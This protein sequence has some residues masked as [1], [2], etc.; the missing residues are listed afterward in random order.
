MT[1]GASRSVTLK[2]MI[3]LGAEK[4]HRVRVVIGVLL[5]I[6]FMAGELALSVRQQSQTFDE[7]CHIFAG[8]RYWK[9]A[10]FGINFEH[11]PLVKLLAA[12]PLL[13]LPLRVPSVTNGYF[14]L[15]EYGS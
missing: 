7:A 6:V 8:Y 14:K 15:V 13:W 1:S 12:V 5:L 2:K 11:P 3:K 10:D 9:T 4:R